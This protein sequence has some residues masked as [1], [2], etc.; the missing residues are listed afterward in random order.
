[1][2]I[3]RSRVTSPS[4]IPITSYQPTYVSIDS[5]LPGINEQNQVY[6]TYSLPNKAVYTGTNANTY[7]QSR[8]TS[9]Q[10]SQ[11]TGSNF[12]SG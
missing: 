1:M 9:D 8:F 7:Q 3:R 4:K 11:L 12:N 10:V 5:T 2:S 6:S